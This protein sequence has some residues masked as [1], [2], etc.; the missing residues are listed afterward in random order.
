MRQL[1][2]IFV[3]ANELFLICMNN[4]TAGK[5]LYQDLVVLFCSVCT[6]LAYFN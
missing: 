6:L 5:I 2:I 4:F 3:N 1:S